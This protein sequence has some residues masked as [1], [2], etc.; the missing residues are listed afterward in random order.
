V[1]RPSLT[2]R[3]LSFAAPYAG[4]IRKDDMDTNK[5]IE[6]VAEFVDAIDLQFGIYLD[7]CAGFQ[8]IHERTKKHQLEFIDKLKVEYPEKANMEYMDSALHLYGEGDPNDPQNIMWHKV[9]Q[10]KFKERTIKNGINDKTVCRNCIVLIYEF[11]ETEY[12]N[13]VSQALSVKRDTI[14]IPII[15]DLRL[16]RHAILHNKS[17]VTKDIVTKAEVIKGYN[18]GQ[19]IIFS[20]KEM[21]GIVQAVK[22]AMDKLLRENVGE[23]PKHRTVWHVR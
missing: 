20:E 7:A 4:V 14:L 5:L 1:L 3:R 6:A 11:W 10:K 19:E 13:R 21:Y 23:D 2:N 12:R 17:R 15:G 18:E 22:A 8:E 16:I 9:T